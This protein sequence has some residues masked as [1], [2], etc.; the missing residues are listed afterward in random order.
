MDKGEGIEHDMLHL[1]YRSNGCVLAM[2]EP[3][4]NFIRQMRSVET[5][6]YSGGRNFAAHVSKK[7]W[8]VVPITSTIETQFSVAPGTARAQ[9]RAH[10]EGKKPESQWSLAVMQEQLRETLQRA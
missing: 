7:E 5:D 8:N 1:H 9:W 3:S 2:G 10:N 6:P 4:I